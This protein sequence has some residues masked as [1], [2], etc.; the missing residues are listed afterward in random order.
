MKLELT[1]EEPDYGFLWETSNLFDAADRV[2]CVVQEDV[3]VGDP[4]PGIPPTDDDL[5][6]IECEP[7]RLFF[8]ALYS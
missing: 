3:A 4:E 6:Q 1:N 7:L 8:A 5:P 2:S